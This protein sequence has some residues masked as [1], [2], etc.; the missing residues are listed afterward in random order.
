MP[1]G[2]AGRKSGVADP[3]CTTG[4][5]DCALASGAGDTEC[6]LALDARTLCANAT[7]RMASNDVLSIAVSLGNR[8]PRIFESPVLVP[9]F[10]LAPVYERTHDNE[11]RKKKAHALTRRAL[12]R[13]DR[14]WIP[15]R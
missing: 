12:C 10:G 4:L 9:I 6:S 8:V 3:I 11:I 7:R 1:T 15:L 14:F 13:S 2:G 5:N